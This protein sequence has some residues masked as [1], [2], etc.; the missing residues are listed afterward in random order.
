MSC[1][2][3]H[4]H[5]SAWRKKADGWLTPGL[6]WTA[7]VCVWKEKPFETDVNVSQMTTASFTFPAVCLEKGEDLDFYILW[8]NTGSTR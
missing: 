8:I 4:S 1:F 2:R 7:A 6:Q 3:H 5:Q